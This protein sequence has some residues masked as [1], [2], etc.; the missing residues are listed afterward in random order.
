MP[1]ARQQ[2]MFARAPLPDIDLGE[3][4]DLEESLTMNNAASA[5]A[6]A[7]AGD[8]NVP[9]KMKI[10]LL[11]G[12]LKQNLSCCFGGKESVKAGIF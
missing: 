3:E 11:V 5:A 10:K 1:I 4:E 7:A 6:S 12:G 9:L 2:T 8:A